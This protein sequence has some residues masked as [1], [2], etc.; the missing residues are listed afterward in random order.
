MKNDISNILIH[1]QIEHLYHFTQARNLSTILK[2]GLVPRNTLEQCNI[3]FAHNDEKR[4]DGNTNAIC[5]SIEFPNDRMFPTMQRKLNTDWVV[6][7]LN[8]QILT[9]FPCAFCWMNASAKEMTSTSLN[10]KETVGAFL[11]LFE[12]RDS[13]PKREELCIPDSY[14]THPQAEVQ[15]FHTIPVEYIQNIY[16]C[17]RETYKKYQPLPSYIDASVNK[18]VFGRR[19]DA[20]IWDQWYTEWYKKKFSPTSIEF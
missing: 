11:E 19:D 12:N 17:N 6:L 8:A 13:F 5:V 4:L 1:R 9:H 20:D 3:P 10:S 15:V 18:T 16:F 14:P 7:R 2:Y